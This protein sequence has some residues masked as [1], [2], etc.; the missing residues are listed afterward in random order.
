CNEDGVWNESGSSLAFVV[1][2]PF[3]KTWWFLTGLTLAGL[4]SVVGAVHYFSTQRLHR[5]LEQM[6]QQEALE[7]ERSRMAR[8]LHDQLG[9]SL[10]QVSLLGDLV[11]S[12]KHAP[13]E[14]AAHARQISQTA[15]ETQRALD[16]IVWTVNPSNDTLE[17]LINYVCKYAQ[18][19]F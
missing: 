14:V 9:A 10:T 5:Q 17:G 16:E 7:K 15:T 13:E 1:E 6:R 19:Y 8:E 11:E 3:W 12:E 2:P 4:A 18:E